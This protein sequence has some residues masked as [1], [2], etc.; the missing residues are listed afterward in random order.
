M[1]EGLLDPGFGGYDSAKVPTASMAR[2]PTMKERLELAVLQA[3][4][5]LAKVKEARDIFTRNPD[6]ERLLEIMQS[7]HF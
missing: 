5:R 3:E 6:L 7:A 2:L 4:E 1:M